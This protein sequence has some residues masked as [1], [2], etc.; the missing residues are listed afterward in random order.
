MAVYVD[1]LFA[2][3]GAYSTRWPYAEACHLLADTEDELIEFAV[4]IGLKA[5]WIQHGH[6]THFDL[7]ANKRKQAVAAGATAMDNHAL[8][9]WMRK[10][11]REAIRSGTPET[12]EAEISWAESQGMR[13]V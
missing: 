3:R 7:T 9:A 1:K 10:K 6:Y 8:V 13:I 11:R 5:R 4:S 2:T 12:D